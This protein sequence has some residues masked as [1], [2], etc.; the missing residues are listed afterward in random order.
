MRKPLLLFALLALFSCNTPTKRLTHLQHEF[1]Q[2]L[3]NQDYFEVKTPQET[4]FLPLPTTQIQPEQRAVAGLL[5]KEANAL[6][7]AALSA[8]Q[9]LQLE[10]IQRALADFLASSAQMFGDPSRFVVGD[11]LQ[12]A[13][14]ETE[15]G[16]LLEK[17]PAYYTE[18]EKRWQIP[19]VP[20]A[21]KALEKAR[22][23]LELLHKMEKQADGVAAERII[24]AQYALKDFIGLC[25]S[26]HL[27]K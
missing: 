6:A 7:K 19:S 12:K 4:Y 11:L 25:Q 8:E 24:S 20:K 5:Q 18:V 14:S 23:A 27:L 21:S 1:L 3:A 26:A 15:G 22:A 9:H 17:I 16:L 10:I 13:H 2:K